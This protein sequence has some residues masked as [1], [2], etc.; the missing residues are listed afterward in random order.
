MISNRVKEISYHF[1]YHISNGNEKYLSELEQRITVSAI[2]ITELLMGGIKK[3]KPIYSL[4]NGDGMTPENNAQKGKEIF[5]DD[6][7]FYTYVLNSHLETQMTTIIEV[8]DAGGKEYLNLFNFLAH[9]L[10]PYQ[11]Q[12]SSDK[13]HDM[14]IPG[15]FLQ[16]VGPQTNKVFPYEKLLRFNR[17]WTYIVLSEKKII[18]SQNI[19]S[20]LSSFH[21]YRNNIMLNPKI[22]QKESESSIIKLQRTYRKETPLKTKL[23]SNFISDLQ[24]LPIRM[25]SIACQQKLGEMIN[26]A[27]A[28]MEAVTQLIS[29]T[30]A[31]FVS[32]KPAKDICSKIGISLEETKI[33]VSIA[34]LFDSKMYRRMYSER[35]EV[36]MQMVVTI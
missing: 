33:I 35:E 31:S 12:L 16:V 26:K 4:L 21:E 10:L 11:R 15:F 29:E 22:T 3:L 1:K 18:K 25:R 28:L 9:F 17:P 2:E 8:K 30:G 32:P 5:I 24:K 13:V 19:D 14:I 34:Q 23:F 20:H 6:L 36:L 27:I 7:E